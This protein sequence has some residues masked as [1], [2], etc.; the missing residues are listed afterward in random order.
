[1]SDT[2]D[3]EE[4]GLFCGIFDSEVTVE[5]QTFEFTAAAATSASCIDADAADAADDDGT[6]DDNDVDV[7]GSAGIFNNKKC[8]FN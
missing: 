8:V 7:G 1:M 3:D 5:R 6:A 4:G 2:D